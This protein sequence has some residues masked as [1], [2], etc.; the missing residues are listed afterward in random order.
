MHIYICIYIYIFGCVCP[1]RDLYF[2]R[3]IFSFLHTYVSSLLS[4]CRFI[5]PPRVSSTVTGCSIHIALCHIKA[6]SLVNYQ[7]FSDE[8]NKLKTSTYVRMK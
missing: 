6:K 4:S 7:M 2:L 5:E 1:L 3:I 8:S